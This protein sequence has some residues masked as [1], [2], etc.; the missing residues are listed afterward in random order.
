MALPATDHVLL[1]RPGD[2]GRRSAGWRLRPGWRMTARTPVKDMPKTRPR[3]YLA[4]EPDTPGA[5]RAGPDTPGG[6]DAI[7]AQ[8]SARR[9]HER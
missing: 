5:R 4:G 1:A 2:A 6:R 3:F 7:S 8:R 9:A